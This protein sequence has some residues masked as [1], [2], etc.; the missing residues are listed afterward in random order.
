[1]RG[2]IQARGA[3]GQ[4]LKEIKRASRQ[5]AKTRSHALKS[6]IGSGKT[7]IVAPLIAG[8]YQSST[9]IATGQYLAAI[10]CASAAGF[11][12]ILLAV[13]LELADALV[14]FVWKRQAVAKTKGQSP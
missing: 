5:P 4:H 1:M 10:K 12:F 13:S 14:D 7:L 2:N 9:L 6:I 11:A 8:C 3:G